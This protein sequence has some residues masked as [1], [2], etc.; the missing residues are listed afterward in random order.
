MDVLV[1]Q[2]RR[3]DALLEN[4]ISNRAA[5]FHPTD[6]PLLGPRLGPRRRQSLGRPRRRVGDQCRR[7]RLAARR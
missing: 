4:R 5:E 7:Q 6:A 3:L 2:G 1:M